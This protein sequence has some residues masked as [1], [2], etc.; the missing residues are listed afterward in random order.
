MRLTDHGTDLSVLHRPGGE[1]PVD[2]FIPY[3]DVLDGANPIHADRGSLIDG[4]ITHDAGATTASPSIS[5][6]AH[7]REAA[8]CNFIKLLEAFDSSENRTHDVRGTVCAVADCDCVSVLPSSDFFICHGSDEFNSVRVWGCTLQGTIIAIPN[9]VEG[10]G[11]GNSDK[12]DGA[13]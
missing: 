13:D 4:A 11:H 8:A 6:I 12:R 9:S 3:E 1:T 7:A 5:S 10:C 2:R